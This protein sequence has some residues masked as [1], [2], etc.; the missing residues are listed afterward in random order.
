MGKSKNPYL[1]WSCFWIG[2]CIIHYHSIYSRMT[3]YKMA[4]WQLFHSEE[5]GKSAVG[6]TL[7]RSRFRTQWSETCLP[8]THGLYRSTVPA[9]EANPNQIK[10]R[11]GLCLG[12]FTSESSRH[13]FQKNTQ[14]MKRN[15]RCHR[16]QS[17]GLRSIFIQKKQTGSIII[18]GG[19]RVSLIHRPSDSFHKS[20]CKCLQVLD[21]HYTQ[22]QQMGLA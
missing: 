3:T 19:N 8:N 20:V 17:T 16:Q 9:E 2:A 13:L 18:D 15:M 7:W 5:P 1:S 11:F 4:C 14:S 6:Q 21:D 12:E 10:G 22:A